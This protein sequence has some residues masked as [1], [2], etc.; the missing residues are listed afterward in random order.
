M[1]GRVV[2]VVAG[3][4]VVAGARDVVEVVAVGEADTGFAAAV[5]QP[6]AAAQQT[7]V[8]RVKVRHMARRVTT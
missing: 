4:A 6:A 7:T 3:A 8:Q 1:A 2:V 5:P